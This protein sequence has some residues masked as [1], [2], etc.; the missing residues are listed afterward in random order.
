M[1]WFWIF[2]W[3]C[4]AQDASR[5]IVMGEE[6]EGPLRT[7]PP[8]VENFTKE[9]RDWFNVLRM[10]GL[11]VAVVQD[12]KII[13]W[14]R[15]GFAN[16]E[17]KAP[18]EEESIFW[19]A[20]VT[21]TFSAVLMM[22]YEAEGK[23]SLTDPVMQ[24]PFVSVGFF[25][26]RIDERV[27]L[28]H[29][30]SHTSEGVPGEIFVYHGGR[31]N[32]I[33]GVFEEISGEK[34]PSA[35]H[36]ELEKRVLKPL[37]M[38][39]TL[40]GYP[41]TNQSTLRA[42][43][44]TP[45]TF[46]EKKREYRVNGGAMNQQV[47]YPSSG[48]LSTVK[49]L[50]TYTAALDEDRLLTRKAYEKMTTPF[51]TNSGRAA[52]YGLGWFTER[53]GDVPLHWAY[54]YGDSDSALL[55]RIPSMKMSL[56]VLSNCDVASAFARLGGGNPLH[57][58]VAVSFLKHFVLNERQSEPRMD[59]SGDVGELRERLKGKPQRIHLEELLSQALLQTFVAE[60]FGEKMDRARKLTGWF[61]DAD[62][63][64][65]AKN[66][67]AAMYLLSK[68]PEAALNEV[69]EKEVKAYENS[70][71]FHPWILRSIAR[72]YEAIGD[73]E[74][75]MSFSHE[76]A[77]ASG[78]EEQSDKLD[79]C[80]YLAEEYARRGNLQKARHYAW[81][82]MVY[83]RQF[84]GNEGRFRESIAQINGIAREEGKR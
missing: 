50:A 63:S 30:I 26:Q 3:A 24:Y 75:A 39:S 48:L 19:L 43:V 52:G 29:V 7:E 61:F 55:L 42:R 53:F 1:R 11:S 21:K 41:G 4:L 78:F 58:P 34:F 62:R 27:Q 14:Q 16:V 15:E 32:F 33:Y 54:G 36:H 70:G 46:D 47:A 84:G 60:K 28:R 82:G 25:P 9:V 57:S 37:K 31:Y 67:P 20:S 59:F 64:E 38:E 66:D 18:I 73:K 17:R 13:H 65:L 72:R 10:P 8:N 22:Q 44:V 40:M 49:D 6:A 35:L 81:R 76:L 80:F 83:T 56:I 5:Y 77:D 51:V 12:G 79:A 68:H 71:A 2:C 69:A 45:Y 74:R 23:L